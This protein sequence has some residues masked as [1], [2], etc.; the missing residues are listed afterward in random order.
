M[1]VTLARASPVDAPSSCLYLAF[2]AELTS[3]GM[4]YP[5][6]YFGSAVLAM[7]PSKI[8]PTPSLMAFGGEGGKWRDSPDAVPALLS[9]SQNTGVLPT[10]F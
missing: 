10:P 6:G 8:L 4:E 5:F 9:S 7:S 2:I 3:Y 1:G